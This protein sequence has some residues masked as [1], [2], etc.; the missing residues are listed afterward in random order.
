M[1]NNKMPRFS[2]WRE[3]L[4]EV[5]DD[6]TTEKKIKEKNIDNSKLIKINPD[7]KEAIQHIGGEIIE[8]K[9]MGSGDNDKEEAEKKNI[10][11][12]QKRA[13]NI[14][15]QVLIKKLMAVRAG[16]EDVTAGYEPEG[17]VIGERLG[18]KGVSR[19]AAAGSIYPGKKGDGDFP[20]S[21]RGAGNKAKRRAGGKVEK[22][23]PTYRAYVLNKEGSVYDDP[24]FGKS[25]AKARK[26]SLSKDPKDQKK[27]RDID[28]ANTKKMVGEAKVDKGRSDYGKASIRNYRRMGPGHDDPAMFDSS[29][30][31][32]KTI[33]KRR[34]EHKARR[35]VK[36]AKVP[37]YKVSEES[38]G[39]KVDGK[40]MSYATM[41]AKGIKPKKTALQSVKDKYKG[42]IYDPKKERKPSKVDQVKAASE[43]KKRQDAD[44]KAYAARAKKAGFKSTQDYTNVV[45]RYGGEDNYKKGRGLGT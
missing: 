45:A 44:N 27:G 1:T 35:G 42:Q 33:D 28:K 38:G 12:K 14:K 39:E 8:M 6:Q 10:A 7:F 16:A 11:S 23:S 25:V 20:D 17:E 29:N 18:G 41:K 32:G 5:V 37:A 2:N 30:K 26:L 3:D 40:F 21:D 36:G 43:R 4:F 24:E 15:K 9:E 34:E 13:N 19:K 31:R 22:K